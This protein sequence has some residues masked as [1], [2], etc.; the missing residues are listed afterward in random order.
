MNALF[1]SLGIESWKAT[2]ALL[3]LPPV[4]LLLAIVVGARL[5][6][7]RRLTAW[8]LILIGVVGLWLTS[9]PAVA[10][11]LLQGLLRP[12]PA[13]SADDRAALRRA[14]QTAI[15]VLG[16]GRFVLAPEYGV[17]VPKPRTLERLR[18]GLWLGRETGLPVA[19]SGGLGWNADP[20][21]TEAD[22]AARVAERDFGRPLRWLESESRDTR[23]NAWRSVALLQP[24]GIRRVVVV[25]HADHMRRALRHFAAAGAERGVQVVAAP[26]GVPASGRLVAGDWLPSP[27]GA[28]STWYVLRE[29]LA[30]AAGS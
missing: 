7:T 1:A 22:V 10:K 16:A 29:A 8:V 11:L 30:L 6:F 26:V 14:P 28:S 12:P 9:T 3:V 23:G 15:V 4:P 17:A 27:G 20:G 13:L 18:Y 19:Y 24:Q 21:P 5:M 25:T 2:V